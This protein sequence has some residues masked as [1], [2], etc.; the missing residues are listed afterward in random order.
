MS[1]TIQ[2]R[3]VV[4]SNSQGLHARP[5]D[6]FARTAGKFESKVEIINGSQRVDGKSI[7]DVLTLAAVQGTELEIEAVGPDAGEALEALVKLVE[8]DFAEDNT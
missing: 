6:L 7:L 4:V 2:R 3:A 1:D 5:A 8:S